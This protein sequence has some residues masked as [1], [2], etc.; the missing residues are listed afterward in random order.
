[1]LEKVKREGEAQAGKE[2]STGGWWERGCCYFS[3]TSQEPLPAQVAFTLKSQ[4][5]EGDQPPL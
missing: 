5:W 2:R 4:S 3:E 1:M